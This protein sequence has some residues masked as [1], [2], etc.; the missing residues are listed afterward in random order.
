M[1]EV[2]TV[3]VPQLG[4]RCYLVHDGRRALVVDPPRDVAAVEAAA[5]EAGLAIAA[6][7]ETHVHN[8]FVS[9]ARQLSERW[10]VPHLAAAAAPLRFLRSPVFDGDKVQVGDLQVEVVATPGHTPEHLAYLVT[11]DAAAAPAL[12]S[13]GSLLFGTVGR[14]DLLG[15]DLAEPLARAQYRS[16]RRL[17]ADLPGTTLLLPTHGFG[18]FCASTTAEATRVA[19]LEEEA[20]RH[21]VLAAADEDAF[22]RDLLD[23]F[24]PYPRYYAHMAGLNQHQ[25][26]PP[27]AP[28]PLDEAGV[29]AAVARGAR[30]VD[31]RDRASYA[32][33]HR[34]GSWGVEHG[35]QVATYLGWLSPWGQPLV[36]V[37]DDPDR[38]TR[39][40]ADL[41]RIGVDDV[42]V[43]A[44]APVPEQPDPCAGYRRL[45]W[46]D[47]AA[48]QAVTTPTVLDVRNRD[49]FAA[50]H[51]E[52][53]H[54]VPL[55]DLD[56]A[57]DRLPPG[58][59]WVHC[60]SGYRASIGASLLHAHGR[61]VVHLDDDV[62]RAA[63]AG[64]PFVS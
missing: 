63:A 62:E 21:P 45:R 58:E 48:E 9:G 29:R 4:N 49:E 11:T 34:E 52:G 43:A 42:A 33:G 15:A 41:H 38:L 50:G 27:P 47:L 25:T 13:G 26:P 55:H 39:A 23:G 19:T 5:E 59:L 1:P 30:V 7:A 32:A 44:V 40:L 17:L 2:V 3:P 64:V 60:R 14:T 51:V 35:D 36:L 37:G 16:V 57:L 18:S 20:R 22:V 12:L 28:A 6:V 46:E 10:R 61:T 24:G 56:D 53:A 31:L 8:D 54:H